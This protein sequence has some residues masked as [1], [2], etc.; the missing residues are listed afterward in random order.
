MSKDY[1]YTNYEVCK[2][3]GVKEKCFR[4]QKYNDRGGFDDVFHKHIPAHRIT[5]DNAGAFLKALILRHSPLGDGEALRAYINDRGKE[6]S[7]IDLCQ[8]HMEY[9]EPGVLR[10]YSDSGHINAWFDEVIAK[11]KFRKGS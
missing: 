5:G 10:R 1:M 8:S 2:N 4:L 11:D 9:P 3:L 7:K 6:P